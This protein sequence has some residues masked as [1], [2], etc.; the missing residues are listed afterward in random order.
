MHECLRQVGHRAEKE[1]ADRGEKR[2][3][4]SSLL[5]RYQLAGLDD[6]QR[7]FSRSVEFEQDDTQHAPY[8]AILRYE[9]IRLVTEPSFSQ[10]AALRLLVQSLHDRGYRQLK[11]Q[12]SFRKGAYLGSQEA[13]VEYPDPAPRI[14]APFEKILGWFRRRAANE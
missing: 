6:R 8:R 13:W 10:D 5:D 1:L 14:A 2:D 3:V 11:T 12:M 7:G 4:M 9:S